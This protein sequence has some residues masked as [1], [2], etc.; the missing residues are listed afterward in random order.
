MILLTN[1]VETSK[2]LE[3]SEQKNNALPVTNIN[4]VK[5]SAAFST[6]NIYNAFPARVFENLNWQNE[7]C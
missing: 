7:R 3:L 5:Y 6:E 2:H 4:I 1:E